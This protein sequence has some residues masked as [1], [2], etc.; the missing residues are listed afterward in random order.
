MCTYVTLAVC[1]FM[2]VCV[3]ERKSVC[4]IILLFCAG[5]EGFLLYNN[6]YHKIVAYLHL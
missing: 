2:H 4:V 1:V 5:R 3:R 6:G